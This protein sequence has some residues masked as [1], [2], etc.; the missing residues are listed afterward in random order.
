MQAA[1][2][3]R[4]A[5]QGGFQPVSKFTGILLKTE[6]Y[7]VASGLKTAS[8]LCYRKYKVDCRKYGGGWV[9]VFLW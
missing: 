1:V 9:L 8:L 4:E 6:A 3:V 5:L 7:Q 2:S